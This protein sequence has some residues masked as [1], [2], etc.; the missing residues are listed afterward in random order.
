M[1]S[2]TIFGVYATTLLLY[3]IN[4]CILRGERDIWSADGIYT[5]GLLLPPNTP[6]RYRPL[7]FK[8]PLYIYVYTYNI[9]IH[10]QYTH[11][12]I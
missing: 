3:C 10:L 11:I 12:H 6:R 7:A 5:R 2:T 9:R 8:E 1:N 4:L